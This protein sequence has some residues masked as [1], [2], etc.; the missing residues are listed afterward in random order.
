[1]SSVSTSRHQD[2]LDRGI[3]RYKS[4]VADQM[5]SPLGT[6][7]DLR[8]ALVSRADH[9]HK[10]KRE[11]KPLPLRQTDQES[12]FRYQ[13]KD[14][15]RNKWDIRVHHQSPDADRCMNVVITRSGFRY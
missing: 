1:M 2:R 5:R 10:K 11:G 14:G 12:R 6:N 4:S 9:H 7:L 3:R 13:G 8:R 15:E